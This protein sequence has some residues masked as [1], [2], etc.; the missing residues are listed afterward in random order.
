MFHYTFF[1]GLLPQYFI[2]AWNR[3][4][5]SHIGR[6]IIQQMLWNCPIFLINGEVTLPNTDKSL[7]ENDAQ[8]KWIML[9][10]HKNKELLLLSSV[11]YA[12]KWGRHTGHSQDAEQSTSSEKVSKSLAPVRSEKPVKPSEKQSIDGQ[13]LRNPV[14]IS[15]VHTTKPGSILKRRYI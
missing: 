2:H 12:G 13:R 1:H 10:K 6:E 9:A 4:I 5:I 3:L 11:I 8:T 7:L 15:T 14:T